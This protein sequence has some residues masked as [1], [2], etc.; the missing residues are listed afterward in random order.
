MMN[1]IN[2]DFCRWRPRPFFPERGRPR[3]YNFQPGSI[4]L[5]SSKAFWGDFQPARWT[6]RAPLPSPLGRLA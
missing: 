3:A 5:L 2:A 4:V 6:L 1:E